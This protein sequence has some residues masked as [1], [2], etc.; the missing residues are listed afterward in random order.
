[1]SP[2]FLVQGVEEVAEVLAESQTCAEAH[3]DEDRRLLVGQLERGEEKADE[4]RRGQAHRDGAP[5]P[6]S[7]HVIGLKAGAERLDE[8]DDEE[9]KAEPRGRE[10]DV[11]HDQKEDFA[12]EHFEVSRLLL[13]QR[14]LITIKQKNQG[15]S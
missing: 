3:E 5:R 11:E 8:P 4:Q 2:L 15:S 14:K 12:D 7:Y 1:M 13:G 10:A 6:Y 9:S